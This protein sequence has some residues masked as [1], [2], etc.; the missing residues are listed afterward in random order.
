M[1]AVLPSVEAVLDELRALDPRLEVSQDEPFLD[2][3]LD[4]AGNERFIGFVQSAL[5]SMKLAEGQ[6]G[7][8]FSTEAADLSRAGIPAVVLGPGDIAAAH[9]RDE[10]LDIEQL[11]LAVEVYGTLMRRKDLFLDS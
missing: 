8:P 10:S 11:A 5:R 4:P 1:H 6:L 9:T 2:P 3:A 7:V